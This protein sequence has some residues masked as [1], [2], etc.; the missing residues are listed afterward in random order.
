MTASTPYTAEEGARI[1]AE[2]EAHPR[3]HVIEALAEAMYIL[4]NEHGPTG[5]GMWHH[6]S[7]ACVLV[8]ML[9]GLAYDEDDLCD[10]PGC[11]AHR[12]CP[13]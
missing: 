5:G 6:L 12:R 3:R 9:P 10:E 11:G 1:R 13:S 4:A 7:H 8:E 2:V